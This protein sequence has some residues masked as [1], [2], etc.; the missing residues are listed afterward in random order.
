MIVTG[1]SSGIGKSLALQL[2]DKGASLALAARNAE[3]LQYVAE[4]YIQL[5]GSA[6]AFPADVA[7]QQQCQNL[8]KKTVEKFDRIDLL[9]NNAGFTVVGKF[10]VGR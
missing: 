6:I 3:K 1:A 9:V 7:D 2:A 5:G 4:E 8:I 10:E